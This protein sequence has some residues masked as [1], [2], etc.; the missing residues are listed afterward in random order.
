MK[1]T[2][3]KPYAYYV[4]RQVGKMAAR[5]VS[6]QEDIMGDLVQTARDTAFGRD[7]DFAGI[8]TYDD[9]KARVPV[10]DYESFRPYADR[11]RAGERDVSWIG[12]PKYFAKTSGTT[13]GVKYPQ[14]LW[15]RPQRAVQLHR[16][17]G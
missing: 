16:R 4:R 12:K 6:A 10:G 2:L 15:H 17:N 5:A 3:L 1:A 7:N 9:F 8:K 13:S 14:P 11:I